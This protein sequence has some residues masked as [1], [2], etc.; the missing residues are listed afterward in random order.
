MPPDRPETLA[1]WLWY[2]RYHQDRIFVREQDKDGKFGSMA[3]STITPEQ[4]GK[5][6][7]RW[8]NEGHIPVRVLTEEE[9]EQNKKTTDEPM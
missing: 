6:V 4:W 1:E 8:L 3:L 5:H 7:A 2:T 9:V